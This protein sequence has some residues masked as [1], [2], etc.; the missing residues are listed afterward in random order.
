MRDDVVYKCSDYAADRQLAIET[1]PQLTRYEITKN[2][3]QQAYAV[4]V[5]DLHNITV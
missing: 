5:R 1:L 2:G 4:L 3:E